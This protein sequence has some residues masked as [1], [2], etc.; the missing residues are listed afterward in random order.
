[1]IYVLRLTSSTILLFPSLVAANPEATKVISAT[2]W[3]GSRLLLPAVQKSVD[4]SDDHAAELAD[5]VVELAEA[6]C[7][8]D[9]KRL[10]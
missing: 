3:I 5:A 4:Y 7:L 2:V 6:L 8:A 9:T 1:M 10:W